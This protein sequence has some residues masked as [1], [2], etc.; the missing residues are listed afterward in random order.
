MSGIVFFFSVRSEHP[1]RYCRVVPTIDTGLLIVCL[2]PVLLGAV[3]LSR[4]CREES[5]S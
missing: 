4:C 3:V 5:R 1:V 2:L